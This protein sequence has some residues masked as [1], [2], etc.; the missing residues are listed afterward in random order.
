M[1]VV[2]DGT[3]GSSV[4]C[5]EISYSSTRYVL[6]VPFFGAR[7]STWIDYY[8]TVESCT[9][10]KAV[11]KHFI[12]HYSILPLLNGTIKPGVPVT[13]TLGHCWCQIDRK[14]SSTS[15]TSATRCAWISRHYWRRSVWVVHMYLDYCTVMSKVVLLGSTMKLS[16]LLRFM[17]TV[18][19]CRN[20]KQANA[21]K[22]W[23]IMV[24][25][26]LW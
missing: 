10:P 5:Y 3:P 22:L 13:S 17:V 19:K 21:R 20:C 9:K 6:V 25:V 18:F 16:C 14:R 26:K 1:F 2:I 11:E 8:C 24:I 23:S 15:S 4:L 12:A 7:T